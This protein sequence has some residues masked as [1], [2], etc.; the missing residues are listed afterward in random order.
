MLSAQCQG[1]RRRQHRTEH[2][3]HTHPIPG[4]KLKFLTP[5]GIEPGP[6]SWKAGTLPT[7]PRRRIYLVYYCIK[8]TYRPTQFMY[9][10]SSQTGRPIRQLAT[11]LWL[12]QVCSVYEPPGV[13]N[14]LII[15]DSGKIRRIRGASGWTL[16][17]HRWSSEFASRSLQVGFAVDGT[18]LNRFSLVFLLIFPT[19]NLIPPFFHTHTFCFISFHEPTWWCNRRYRPSSLIFSGLQYRNLS[20]FIPRLGPVSDESSKVEK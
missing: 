5:P 10:A 16:A 20:H 7:T 15:N 14:Y 13:S 19:T 1:L 12:R 18:G 4:Q 17:S 11:V 6:P 2:K 9:W 8:L 3:G